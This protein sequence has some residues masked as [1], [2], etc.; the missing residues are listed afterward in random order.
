MFRIESEFSIKSQC[1][2]VLDIF[3]IRL[4]GCVTSEMVFWWRHVQSENWL[5]SRK[6]FIISKTWC[7]VYRSEWFPQRLQNNIDS[8]KCSFI[9]S[10]FFLSCWR[11][12]NV[13]QMGTSRGITDKTT[14]VVSILKAAGYSM[15]LS[16]LQGKLD[17]IKQ[18]KLQKKKNKGKYTGSRLWLTDFKRW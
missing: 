14:V 15:R 5:F 3:C 17:R 18:E 10:K 12:T 6:A 13:T 16:S 4:T 2:T 9:D 1:I 7:D 11:P 8:P